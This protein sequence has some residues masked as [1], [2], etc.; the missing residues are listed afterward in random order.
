M[1]LLCSDTP[2]RT[3]LWRE[4]F[5]NN[6]SK[7]DRCEN[8]LTVKIQQLNT[9]I[10]SW[11]LSHVHYSVTLCCFFF[12]KSEWVTCIVSM[13]SGI[14]KTT[15]N[16]TEEEHWLNCEGGW[17][18]GSVRV[19][20]PKQGVKL[21][22]KFLSL[23]KGKNHTCCCVCV[24]RQHYNH[25]VIL[26]SPRGT[27]VK[28]L[29]SGLVFLKTPVRRCANVEVYEAWRMK[30]AG[31]FYDESSKRNIQT[32][33]LQVKKHSTTYILPVRPCMIHMKWGMFSN[34]CG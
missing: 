33:L 13:N 14:S 10:V 11:P 7:R 34:M 12:C 24:P 15:G 16:R 5:R 6:F 30:A 9:V 19:V 17:V 2:Q 4:T 27:C 28:C 26:S 8:T 31:Q 1:R 29:C 22:F 25:D 32:L 20:K 23:I 18:G 21:L 3:D